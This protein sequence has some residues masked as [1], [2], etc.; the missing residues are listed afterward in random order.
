MGR[1][2]RGE[3]GVWAYGRMGVWAYG[4]MGVWAYGRMG[5][6]KSSRTQHVRGVLPDGTYGTHGTYGLG[7]LVA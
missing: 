6:V 5:V 7:L 2:R 4:R 3:G 1:I